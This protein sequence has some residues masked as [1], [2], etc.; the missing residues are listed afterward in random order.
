MHQIIS[1]LRELKVGIVRDQFRVLIENRD[2]TAFH[3]RLD[4]SITSIVIAGR[5][6]H[7]RLMGWSWYSN[8]FFILLNQHDFIVYSFANMFFYSVAY[9]FYSTFLHFTFSLHNYISI[10]PRLYI[11]APH[12]YRVCPKSLCRYPNIYVATPNILVAGCRFLVWPF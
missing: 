9:I 11:F 1:P 6:A 12:N 2:S 5:H 7:T 4:W 8:I 3:S 10:I